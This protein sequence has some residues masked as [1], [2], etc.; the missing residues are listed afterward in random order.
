MQL[1]SNQIHNVDETYID[2]SITGKILAL[3]GT[4]YYEL[5]KSNSSGHITLVVS[6]TANGCAMNI[7]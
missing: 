3:K 4:N 7:Y 1:S 2:L 6:I 5:L